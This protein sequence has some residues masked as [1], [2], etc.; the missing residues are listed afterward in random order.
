MSGVVKSGERNI[1][2]W[3]PLFVTAE[4][5]VAALPLSYADLGPFTPGLKVEQTQ[6]WGP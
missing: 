6:T 2:S 1:N 5:F 4:V 3:G